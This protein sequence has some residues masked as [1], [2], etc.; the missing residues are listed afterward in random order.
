MTMCTFTYSQIA[1]LR[2]VYSAYGEVKSSGFSPMILV[3][4]EGGMIEGQTLKRTGRSLVRLASVA[5]IIF[6]NFATVSCLI[7]FGQ[8]MQRVA[9]ANGCKASL[10]LRSGKQFDHCQSRDAH[11]AAF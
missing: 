6:P 1:S 8:P 5:S 7:R 3:M 2:S 10:D 9:F 11:D 4:L